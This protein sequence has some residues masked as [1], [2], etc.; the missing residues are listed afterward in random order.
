[1]T[2][3][4]L[5]SVELRKV[6]ESE[7]GNFTPWLA[8]DENLALLGQ[9]IGLDDLELEAQEKNVGPFRAD[10][11]AKDSTNGNWVL[12][13]NQLE[14]TDHTHLGQLIT[15]AAGLKAASIVW[16]ADRFTEEH[17]A[18]L[19]WLNE[20]T[21]ERINF[22]GLEIELWR[23][24]ES[25]VAPKFNMVCKPNEWTKSP[26]FVDKGLSET[27]KL[28]LA[29]WTALR[30]YLQSNSKIRMG[31][32]HPNMWTTFPVGRS[33]FYLTVAISRLKEFVQVQLVIY[34]PDH[35]A[36]FHLLR[37]QETEIEAK[38][39]VQMEWRELP[40][41]KESH[42]RQNFAFDPS[43]VEDWPV[44]HETIR[45]RLEAFREVFSPMVKELELTGSAVTD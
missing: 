29:Y 42:V 4:K 5:T 35:V 28:Y 24:G 17:R 7:A 9:K 25:Q 14:R 12:I 41:G 45:E 36:Y 26:P 22:F 39:A 31:K 34:G 44:Q 8:E 11:L 19:D 20:V 1:M 15:Y 23:I 6:W 38:L 37:E 30:E 2:L 33:G 43:N 18:A 13:E 21:D 3:G 32:P 40:D 16:V 10:I 27:G